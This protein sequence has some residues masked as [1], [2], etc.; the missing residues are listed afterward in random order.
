MSVDGGYSVLH[1]T[2][3]TSSQIRSNYSRALDRSIF[4]D[5]TSIR[6]SELVD[7]GIYALAVSIHYVYGTRWIAGCAGNLENTG[8]H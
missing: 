3:H 5:M 6:R 4:T 1:I 2:D 8:K 7:V